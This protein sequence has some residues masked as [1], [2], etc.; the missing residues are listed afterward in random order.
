MALTLVTTPA[1]PQSPTGDELKALLRQSV[2][3]GALEEIMKLDD[4][5]VLR[6][7]CRARYLDMTD[8][9]LPS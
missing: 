1:P 4:C 6:A 3:L 2:V 8:G 9:R 5:Q 7:A